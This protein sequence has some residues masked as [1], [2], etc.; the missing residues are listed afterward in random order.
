MMVLSLEM[1]VLLMPLA[2]S[3]LGSS[4]RRLLARRCYF[5]LSRKDWIS[6]SQPVVSVPLVLRKAFSGGT[7]RT[8]AFHVE[9][10]SNS[11]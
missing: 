8:L 7:R 5:R 11:Y 10:S 4:Q 3:L 2:F 1:M 9:M 6:G